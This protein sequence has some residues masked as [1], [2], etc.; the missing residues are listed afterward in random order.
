M[1]I[2]CIDY[3]SLEPSK[4]GVEKI[5]VITDHIARY[6]QA[7][8]T[9]NQ[10]ARN[11]AREMFDNIIVHYGF[12]ACTHSDQ[13]QCFE[14]NL[15]EELCTIANVE[16]SCTTPYHPKGNGQVKRF[17]QTFLQMFGTMEESKKSDWKAYSGWNRNM[18]F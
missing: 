16:N 2:V 7:I 12:P 18:L 9:R 15:V 1:E 14:S 5:I 11:A 17:N 8:P 13:S 10:T 4:G 6:A 3:P